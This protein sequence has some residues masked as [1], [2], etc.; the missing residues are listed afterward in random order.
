MHSFKLRFE[1]QIVRWAPLNAD[2]LIFTQVHSVPIST[3]AQ[4]APPAGAPPRGPP[5]L[6][7]EPPPGVPPP[8]GG[9][10]HFMAFCR[11]C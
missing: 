10:V 9:P 3:G 4:P 11:L 6:P 5:P 7:P 2:K 1:L 8:P